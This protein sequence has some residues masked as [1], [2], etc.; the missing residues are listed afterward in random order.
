MFYLVAS[1][2]PNTQEAE[3][4]GLWVQGQPK[5]D[6]LVSSQSRLQCEILSQRGKKSLLN[7]LG[8]FL[9]LVC[10]FIC[11]DWM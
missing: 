8:L 6:K 2:Y 10:L 7:Y 1:I 9:W 4:E 11:I 3:A 5:L